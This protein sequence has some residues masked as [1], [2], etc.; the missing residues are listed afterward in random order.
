MDLVVGTSGGAINALTVALGLTREDPDNQ[1]QD[2]NE[3]LD[4]TW[5][6][7]KQRDF[8][9][10]LG[11]TYYLLA[12]ATALF[13]ALLV[14]W[15]TIIVV[16]FSRAFGRDLSWLYRYLG[17][18]MLALALLDALVQLSGWQIDSH[19][20]HLWWHLSLLLTFDL[21]LT[22]ICLGVMGLLTMYLLL[23]RHDFKSCF[24]VTHTLMRGG[25]VIVL[26]ALVAY[27]LFKGKTLSQSDI[28][29][30][31][32]ADKITRLVSPQAAAK[33]ASAK[34]A[35][36]PRILSTL[37]REDI[38]PTLKRDLIITGSL[39][40]GESAAAAPGLQ[41]NA[42]L[43]PDLYFYHNQ[44]KCAGSQRDSPDAAVCD[45]APPADSLG[46][47]KD[48]EVGGKNYLLDV[49][50]GSSSI[51]PIFP[52]RPLEGVGNIVDGGF[53]HNSPIEAAVMWKAT[54]IILI[55]ASPLTRTSESYLWQNAQ[56]AFNH[57]YYQAQLSDLRAHGKVE[58]FILRPEELRV[59][60][61]MCTFD[62]NPR[63]VQHAIERG[64]MD[65]SNY[66]NPHFERVPGEPV[67]EVI[68][69]QDITSK[70]VVCT[71]NTD[72]ADG[73]ASVARQN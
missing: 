71:C 57:L 14:A 30:S 13:Q 69:F 54:H 11:T 61:S 19:G 17:V 16:G 2:N 33:L 43:P 29:E 18:A 28:V 4:K 65:A 26:A 41:L 25:L 48:F 67:F 31:T 53:A 60:P 56:N 45:P 24:R 50:I 49:V 47:F 39:L 62:F 36:M 22:A 66:V 35:D 63:A 73:D 1:S 32:L 52:S 70:S 15:L 44:R 23:R 20:T 42:S 68:D 46:R 5:M 8:F 58:M 3:R 72:V 34:K 9:S 40:E 64:A 38:A 55:E 27:S 37:S 7:F 12:L 51:Y 21:Y 6:G 59:E 10:P